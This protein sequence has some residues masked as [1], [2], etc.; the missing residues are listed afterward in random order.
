MSA[1]PRPAPIA[2]AE[3]G[4]RSNLSFLEGAS[5]PE[6][7]ALMAQSLGLSAIGLAD[8]NSVAGV[9][10]LHMAAKEAGLAYHP[11]ARLVFA[12]GTPDLLAYPKNR[13]GW[14]GLCRLLS[15]GNLRAEKGRCHLLLEDLAD[16]S[17]HLALVVVPPAEAHADPAFPA[18]LQAIAAAAGSRVFLA[19]V[20]AYDGLDQW[21]FE[22]L[23]ALAAK[24]RMT[25][26]A[27]N[28]VLYHAPDRRPLADVVTAIRHHVPIASAG[29]RLKPNAERHLKSPV[30]MAR[31]FRD[32]PDALLAT[33]AFDR[34]LQFSLDELR[35][36]YPDEAIPGETPA[37]TLRRL[38]FEGARARY[39]DGIP[40][41]VVRQ[42]AYELKLI[43][44]LDYEP[45]FLTVWDIVRFAR[46][47]GILCQGRG[48]AA[49]ST[50][51]F[52]IG[53]TEVDPAL[54]DLLFERFIS[55]DRRDPTD[56][57]VEF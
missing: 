18:R 29:F 35:Y 44:E 27:S 57:D 16:W 37:E 13:A 5:H 49:N 30:D 21:R 26:M 6:E 36:E 8:R 33:L 54:A 25:P 28:D 39:P 51:C 56:I 47:R 31:L 53:I 55:P 48:S 3:F 12:D 40:D 17:T 9:V 41:K 4:L 10:R 14:A 22:S 50:V 42:I 23:V 32:H 7:I 15:L 20:P 11:G 46:S 2:Y 43:R 52:C 38:T 45:Y 1:S 24:A 19:L 34:L